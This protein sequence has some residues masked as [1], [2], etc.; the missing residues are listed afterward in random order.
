M[1]GWV[2]ADMVVTKSRDE[3]KDN[4]KGAKLVM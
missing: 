3:R 1:W 2:W 4:A